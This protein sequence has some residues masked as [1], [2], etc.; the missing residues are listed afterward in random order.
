[1]GDRLIEVELVKSPLAEVHSDASNGGQ[2]LAKLTRQLVPSGTTLKF[3]QVRHF[4]QLS[5]G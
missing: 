3:S 2:Q 5:G 1:M 4:R